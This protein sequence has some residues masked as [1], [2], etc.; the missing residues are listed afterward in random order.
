MAV[1]CEPPEKSGRPLTHWTAHELADE[2]VKRGIVA[3][4]SPAQ[5]GRYLREAALQPHKSRSWLNTTE[6]DPRRFQEQVEAICDTYQAAP[7]LEKKHHTHTV[8]VDEMTGIQALDAT[9][10][11][12]P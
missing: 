6:K 9:P 4:I 2:V 8:C 7:A 11:V 3:S 5:V 1:A 12:C 10:P